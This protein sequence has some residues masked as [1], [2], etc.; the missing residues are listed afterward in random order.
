MAFPFRRDISSYIDRCP[1]EILEKIIRE[2][3][4]SSGLSRPN[5]VCHTYNN[6]QNVSV[7]FRDITRR[8][9][10]ILPSIHF[11]NGGENGFVSVRTLIQKYGTASGLVMEVKRIV[12]SP[13][14]REAYLELRFRGL[15]WF[16]IRKILWKT[17]E[18]K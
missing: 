10:W 14:W 7:R 5:H 13:E 9:D 3:L 6:L 1:N 2:A 8:L 4:L 12:A 18:Q 15:G 11:G 17:K 16:V